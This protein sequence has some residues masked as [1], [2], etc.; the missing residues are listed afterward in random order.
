MNQ[1]LQ[2]VPPGG[3]GGLELNDLFKAAY[4]AGR[5]CTCEEIRDAL[6]TNTHPQI[7]RRILQAMDIHV[8]KKPGGMKLWQFWLS[9]PRTA[10]LNAAAKRNGWEPVSFLTHLV[11]EIDRL[12]LYAMFIKLQKRG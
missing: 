2:V 3:D 8:D 7:I 12:D 4:L 6:K 5:G 11:S 1:R 10:G 9:G